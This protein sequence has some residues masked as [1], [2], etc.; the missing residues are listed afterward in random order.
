[1]LDIIVDQI[2]KSIDIYDEPDKL[3]ALVEQ[4]D[5]LGKD[6]FWYLDEYK[7]YSILDSRIMERVIENKWRGKY[8][9]NSN[10]LH[11]SINYN[12]FVDKFRLFTSDTVFSELWF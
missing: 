7:L 3:T 6:C 1:M 4:I 9:I 11:Y 10:I 2:R 8:E 12:L 5:Y